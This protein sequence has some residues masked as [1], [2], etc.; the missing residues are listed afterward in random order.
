MTPG[1]RCTAVNV[2]WYCSSSHDCRT[3]RRVGISQ[4]ATILPRAQ[5]HC[6]KCTRQVL[7]GLCLTRDSSRRDQH[8]VVKNLL[9]YPPIV[10]EFSLPHCF[11]VPCAPRTRERNSKCCC[12]RRER[13]G[14]PLC[15]FWAAEQPSGASTGQL[16]EEGALG[17]QRIQQWG[18]YLPWGIAACRGVG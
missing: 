17:M 7:D 11:E 3:S 18:S 10:W 15:K 9:R 8:C 4:L 14:R 1:Q 12:T 5:G 6:Y 2:L 16:G 13:H